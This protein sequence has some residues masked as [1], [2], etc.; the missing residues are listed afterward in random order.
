MPRKVPASA[1]GTLM[2]LLV[3]NPALAEEA[4]PPEFW[5]YLLDYSDDQGILLDPLE[6]DTSEKLPRTT[7]EPETAAPAAVPDKKEN[8]R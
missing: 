5:Q 8:L 4:P 1:L 2:L 3:I 6:L 7:V